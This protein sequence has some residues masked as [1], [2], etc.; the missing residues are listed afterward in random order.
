M[1][2]AYADIVQYFI[3]N[4]KSRLYVLSLLREIKQLCISVHHTN[5]KAILVAL[6]T[7]IGSHFI[8]F[9]FLMIHYDA[10]V[11]L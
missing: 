5:L 9:S 1:T 7:Y 6:N 10:S 8:V 11:C 3:Y 2:Q 4:I